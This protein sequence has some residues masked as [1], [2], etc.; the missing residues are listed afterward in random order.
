MSAKAR[1]I[2]A[3]G[4]GTR[5]TPERSSMSVNAFSFSVVA[6]AAAGA[7]ATDADSAPNV[8]HRRLAVIGVGLDGLSRAW[9]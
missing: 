2:L 3:A 1:I 8:R 9:Q 6:A 7:V 4:S 5:D